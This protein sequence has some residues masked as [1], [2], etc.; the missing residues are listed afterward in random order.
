MIERKEKHVG[1]RFD[2]AA[3]SLRNLLTQIADVKVSRRKNGIVYNGPDIESSSILASSPGIKES[4]SKDMIT[5]H[6]ERG[7][8]KVDVFIMNVFQ[9]G[10]SVG[11]EKAY[12]DYSPFMGIVNSMLKANK[13][14]LEKEKKDE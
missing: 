7:R 10:Y 2:L 11:Y 14:K 6:N 9:L 3:K 8:D 13:E 1:F 12:H 5:Y 4:F